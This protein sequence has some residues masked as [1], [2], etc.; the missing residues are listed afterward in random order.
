MPETLLII[1]TFL[2][3]LI[4]GSFLNVCIY[5][6]P[7]GLNLGGRSFC[8]GCKEKVAWFDNLPVFSFIL[9][10]GK[11][12]KCE[13]KIS[14]QYPI[15]EL[16]TAGLSVLTLW[17]TGFELIPYFVWFL[18]YILPL[19]TLSFIDMKHRIIPDVISIPGIPI[20]FL[21]T[22]YMMWPNWQN[23]LTF[24]FL[25]MLAGGGS[26]LILAQLYI[27]IRKREGLGGGDVKLCAMLGAFLGW[28]AIIFVFFISSILAIIFAVISTLISSKKESGPLVIPYGPFLSLAAMIYFFY[29]KEILEFYFNMVLP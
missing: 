4:F 11:C 26:L 22:L 23:A 20:G 14:F 18:L 2:L 24:S 15:V 19:I 25:G 13:E 3:G 17:R 29:G 16:L 27:W 12:R 10:A 5:R 8:P 21:V 9:L 28:K 6:L 1:E 7:L